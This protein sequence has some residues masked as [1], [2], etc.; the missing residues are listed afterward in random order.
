MS[1]DCSFEIRPKYNLIVSQTI[2]F[3]YFYFEKQIQCFI[4]ALDSCACKAIFGYW[5]CHF[6]NRLGRHRRKL[7]RACTLLGLKNM[8][9]YER[10]KSATTG[11]P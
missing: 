10:V 11:P 9:T 7:K 1:D 2:F 6:K 8:P 5:S 4:Q 3:I